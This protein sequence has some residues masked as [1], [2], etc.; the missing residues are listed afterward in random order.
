MSL[1]PA[2]E[3]THSTLTKLP[4]TTALTWTLGDVFKITVESSDKT[5]KETKRSERF[6]SS[7]PPH[8][9]SKVLEENFSL[10][11]GVYTVTEEIEGGNYQLAAG[12]YTDT[13]TTANPSVEMVVHNKANSVAKDSFALNLSKR[14]TAKMR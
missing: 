7:F 4:W 14:W 2:R 9:H 3:D 8:L 10:K 12:E 5:F 6:S 1:S 13:V 11:N